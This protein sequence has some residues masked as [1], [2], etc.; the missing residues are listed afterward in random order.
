MPIHSLELKKIRNTWFSERK[1]ITMPY[2][3]LIWALVVTENISLGKIYM[4]ASIGQLVS[5]WWFNFKKLEFWVI[6]VL[7]YIPRDLPKNYFPSCHEEKSVEKCHNLWRNN[8]CRVIFFPFQVGIIGD[9]SFYHKETLISA[10]TERNWDTW[11]YSL[12]LTDQYKC[13]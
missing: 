7:I 6:F 2:P 9:K 8:P 1:K 5:T 13:V 12:Y 4:L 3:V 10:E 11:V